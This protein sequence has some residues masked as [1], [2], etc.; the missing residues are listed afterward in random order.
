VHRDSVTV[1][2]VKS[3]DFVPSGPIDF[4]FLDSLLELRVPE[5]KYFAP[6]LN[7]GAVVAFHDTGPHKAAGKFGEDV[8]AI[9]GLRCL[10]LNTPRG[11][12]IAQY[13]KEG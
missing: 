9:P 10:Q 13:D 6:H 3:L 8:R 1:N 12:T 11:I 7:S 2:R 5:F 4:L